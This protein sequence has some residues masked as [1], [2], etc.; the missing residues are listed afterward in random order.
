MTNFKL[1]LKL[2]ET[3]AEILKGGDEYKY[4]QIMKKL[5]K[6]ISKVDRLEN[7]VREFETELASFLYEKTPTTF[8][9]N[10]AS[11]STTPPIKQKKKGA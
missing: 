9:I 11:T 3:V 4:N 6:V 10:I 5:D 2:H 8:P 7:F 1:Y